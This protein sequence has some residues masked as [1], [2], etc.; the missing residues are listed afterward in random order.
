MAYAFLKGSLHNQ[1]GNLM[2]DLKS[3]YSRQINQYPQDLSTA[4]N[5]LSTHQ[6]RSKVTF[7]KK[8]DN[9]SEDE[10]VT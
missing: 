4:L 6:K 2:Y 5:L 10:D 7:N 1:Y 8:V 9:E 3:Q